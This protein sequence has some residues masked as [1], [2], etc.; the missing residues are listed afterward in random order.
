[1]IHDLKN[2]NRHARVSVK[3]VSEVGVG[4]IAAGVAKAHADVVLISGYDGG[5]GSSP[6]TS[7]QHAGLPWE[8]GLAETHQT[9]VLNNRRSR[10]AVETDG[11]LKTGRDV[12]IAALLGAEEFGFA[13]APLV[14]LGCI[15]MRVCHLNTCPVGVATQDPRLRERFTGKPEHVVNFMRFIAE[16]LREHMAR[17]GFRTLNE[18]IGRVDRLEAKQAVDHWKARGFDFSNVLYQPD[19]GPEVGRYRQIDQDHGLE[20]SLDVTKLLEICRPAIERGERVQASLPIRNVNRVVGTITGSEITRRWGAKGLPD[21]TVRIH[22]KGSAGQ[23]FGA[24]MPRGMTFTLEGDAN[25]YLGKGLS[26]GKLVIHPPAGSAFVP[27]ENIIIGNVAFYGATA[28]EAYIRGMAGERFCVRNSGVKAVVEA[29]GDHGC[30]YMTGGRVVVLG[31]AGRN[32]GA[33]M[34][35]GVAYVLD[36]RGDFPSR[37]NGQMVAAGRLEDP[38]EI[39]EVRAMVE[40][41]LA[42]TQ[43]ARAKDVLARW[44]EMA[45]RFVRVMPKDYARVLECIQRAHEQG[46]SGEEAV[47]A[48]FEQNARDLARVGG[49]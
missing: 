36:E 11:Q 18:M 38:E 4:T 1:L 7:L 22:F 47:M 43:S 9:L 3:L 32:F 35:G 39:A 19:L 20:Q 41:H 8:L 49:N 25:D 16:D 28:G 10:I 33:G 30:V 23:S 5:T 6:H 12:V 29:I 44:P 31:S 13:T 48:A 17:L 40:R 37:V 26:G 15:M 14:A 34:S 45:G 21:D 2:S 27:E 42:Y 24:F 46:L